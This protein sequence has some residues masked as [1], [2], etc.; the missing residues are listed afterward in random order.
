M[1]HMVNVYCF[2]FCIHV[3]VAFSTA[4]ESQLHEA[5][6]QDETQTAGEEERE[7]AQQTL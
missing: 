3:L 7:G 1:Q 4:N 5:E 2:V 6:R